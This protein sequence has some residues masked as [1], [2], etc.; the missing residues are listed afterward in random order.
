VNSSEIGILVAGVL[1]LIV[2]T[3]L[4]ADNPLY[5]LVEHIFIGASLGWV[6]VMLYRSVILG[7]LVTPLRDDPSA[8]LHLLIPLALGLLL[9]SRLFVRPSWLDNSSLGFLVGVGIALAIAGSLGGTIIPQLLGTAR[10]LWP[11]TAGVAGW[12]D[13]LN[14]L[15]IIAGVIATLL[16]FRFTRPQSGMEGRLMA[17]AATTGQYTLMIAFGAFFASLALA[18]VSLLVGRIDFLINDWLKVFGQIL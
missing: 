15:V 12:L 5:R 4:F 6:A 17:R 10:P 13:V 7:Q 18:R 2:F 16:F 9:L 3:Y 8:N 11:Q 1:T 14:N